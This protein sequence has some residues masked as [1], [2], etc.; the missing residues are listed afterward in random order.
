MAIARERRRHRRH[1]APKEGSRHGGGEDP[2]ARR[3]VEAGGV[4]ARGCPTGLGRLGCL[5]DESARAGPGRPAEEV[6]V[7]RSQT[8]VRWAGVR[9]LPL[10]ELTPLAEFLLKEVWCGREIRKWNC[11]GQLMCS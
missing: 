1:D 2:E 8:R 10:A 6:R 3:A 5:P 11:D 4:P 9:R 7:L